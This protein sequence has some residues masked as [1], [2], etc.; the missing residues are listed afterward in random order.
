MKKK[1]SLIP[2]FG[3]LLLSLVG[4]GKSYDLGQVSGT[5]TIAGKPGNKIRIEF[6]PEPEVE[7]PASAALTDA[8]GKYS[9]ELILKDGNSEAGAVVGQHRVALFDIQLAESATGRDVPIRLKS[10]YSSISSTPLRETVVS[11]EQTIDITI[12]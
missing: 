1:P 6:V 11:G 10:D 9:L 2:I 3:C 4:C 7:G 8:N 12:P 5:V